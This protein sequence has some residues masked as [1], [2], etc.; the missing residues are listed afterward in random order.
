MYVGDRWHPTRLG[1]SEYVWL[2]LALNNGTVGMEYV[3]EFK[4]DVETGAL[5]VPQ[6][7]LISGNA[8][9]TAAR[10]SAGHPPQHGGDGSYA[11]YWESS[12]RTLPVTVD[13][14]LTQGQPI[15]RVD[16][17][18][19]GIGGSEAYYQY[20]LYGSSDNVTF[21]EL[22]DRSTNEDLGFTSDRVTPSDST[23]YRYLRIVIS[24]FVNFTNGNAP[25]YNPG[26]YEIK[27]YGRTS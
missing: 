7:Q 17:T 13:V 14:D 2:P 24:R 4:F 20:K 10:S 3:P 21:T 26:L 8:L 9:V 22:A 6:V 18:W 19:R 1:A 15:G 27:V 23:P 11:T 25:G 16:I 5:V 12:D